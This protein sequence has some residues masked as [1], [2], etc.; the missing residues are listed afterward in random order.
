[1][2]YYADEYEQKRLAEEKLAAMLSDLGDIGFYDE[3]DRTAPKQANYSGDDYYSTEIVQGTY[4]LDENGLP[5]NPVNPYIEPQY[6]SPQPMV[7]ESYTAPSVSKVQTNGKKWEL[8]E[9]HYPGTKNTNVYSVRCNSNSQ[10]IMNNIL[11]KEAAL[12]LVNLLNEGRML[13]DA[14]VLGIISSGVQFTAVMNEVIKVSRE[15]QVVLNESRYDEAKDLDII[16]AEK[17]NEAYKLKERVLKFLKS[18]GYIK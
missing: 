6:V 8:V 3:P 17:K 15:R 14:K 18:E 9:E 16:I 2:S 10:V 11:M 13:T 7:A 5:I 4:M 12:T 1:M